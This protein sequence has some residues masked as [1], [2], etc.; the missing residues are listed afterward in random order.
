[1]FADLEYCK[2]FIFMCKQH[3]TNVFMSLLISQKKSIL[4]KFDIFSFHAVSSSFA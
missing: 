3:S 4:N 1:M 2:E